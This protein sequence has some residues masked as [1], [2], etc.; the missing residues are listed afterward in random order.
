MEHTRAAAPSS[1]FGIAVILAGLAMLGPF[2]INAYLPSFPDMERTLH[3]DRVALQQT[4]SVYFAAFAF[5]SLWHG[6]ISDAFGRRRVVLAGLAVY[7]AASL[8]CALATRVEHLWP[9]RALQGFS[10]GAGIV[11]GRAVVRDLYDGP[12]ARRMMSQVVMLYGVAPAIA[13]LVGGALQLSF[14]WR[15]VF[16]FLALMAAVLFA[17]VALRLPE[18]LPP[19]QRRR[20]HAA[21]LGRGYLALLA[22]RAFMAWS[23]AYALMFG[24][25]FIYVLSAPV[26]LMQHLGL[27]ETDFLWLFGPATLGLVGGS[28][29]AGRVAVR[30]SVRRTLLCG[31]GLMAAATLFNLGVC[32]AAPREPAWYVLYVAVFNVGMSLAIPTL[33]VRA[34]DCVPERRGMGSSVQL[35]AQTGFNAFMAAL[36]A[37][38]LW[39]SLLSLAL[40]AA[41]LFLC[42][43]LGT[44]LAVRLSR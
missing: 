36:L 3:T 44:L 40:G 30:W 29:L 22:N 37:P 33:A 8:G 14:G 17:A 1:Q 23:L 27:G 28:A 15:S 34:L 6:A 21:D 20:F 38:L 12:L 35:F 2:S 43:A 18:T 4:I 42:A 26:F 39:G 11:I 5:M 16:L 10:A 25:F 24:A 31:F 32:L 7:A 13:P 9:L 41:A 19:A